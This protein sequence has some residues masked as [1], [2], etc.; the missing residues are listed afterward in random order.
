VRY[1]FHLRK[2]TET[3]TQA[4]VEKAIASAVGTTVKV[5]YVLKAN[6]LVREQT[7]GWADQELAETVADDPLIQTAVSLGGVLREPRAI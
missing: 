7:A 2:L 4:Q 3:D 5:R 6:W 1:D